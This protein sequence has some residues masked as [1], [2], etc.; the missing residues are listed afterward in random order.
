MARIIDPNPQPDVEKETSC[1]NCGAK[2]AYVPRDVETLK[3]SCMG[4]TDYVDV[5]KCPNCDTNT[6]VKK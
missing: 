4:E 5:V 3:I 2:I 1:R 6:R